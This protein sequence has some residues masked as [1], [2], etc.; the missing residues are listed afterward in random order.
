[1]EREGTLGWGGGG[2]A[3]VGEDE[4]EDEVHGSN[5]TAFQMWFLVVG[6]FAV[7]ALL[8]YL[9]S[10]KPRGFPPGKSRARSERRGLD[11]V[12]LATPSDAVILN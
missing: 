6:L 4:D 8:L 7:T 10:R 1:M 5:E 9:D 11:L 2:G 12:S 3:T